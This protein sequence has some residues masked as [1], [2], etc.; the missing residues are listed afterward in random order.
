MEGNRHSQS[1]PDIVDRVNPIRPLK[2]SPNAGEG[3]RGRAAESRRIIRARQQQ[4]QQQRHQQP[5]HSQRYQP[6]HRTT[7]EAG[8]GGGVMRAPPARS[9]RQRS[10]GSRLQAVA[11]LTNEATVC[12]V[13]LRFRVSLHFCDWLFCSAR[14][15]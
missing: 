11:D 4:Q 12:I 6:K 14:E 7:A 15:K 13:A 10:T 2:H 8:S 9:K 5:A 1:R 3:L